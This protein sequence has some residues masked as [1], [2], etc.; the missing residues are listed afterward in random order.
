MA[1]QKKGLLIGGLI[2]VLAAV[3]GICATVLPDVVQ[4]ESSQGMSSS[5]DSDDANTESTT[6]AAS[7]DQAPDTY[8]SL[9]SQYYTAFVKNDPEVL[10]RLMAP[11]EY[12]S[13][14]MEH[15]GKTKQDVIDTYQQAIADTMADW[16]NQCGTDVSVSFSITGMSEQSDAFLT[17]WTEDMNEMLGADT[18]H[19][20][21]AVTLQ[22][23]RTLK[24]SKNTITEVLSPTLI[25]VDGLWYVLQ[26][27]STANQQPT[28]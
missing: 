25:Q 2:L 19:A 12:W 16:R 10:Y 11:P 5:S 27:D 6:D 4:K 8:Q 1:I 28:E 9:M 24:G 7:V 20:E 21:D 17:E 13:Y 14:Y 22:V 26:E 18:V 3:G 23:E 15:Y